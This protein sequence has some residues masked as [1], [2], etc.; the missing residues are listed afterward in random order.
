MLHVTCHFWCDG[1]PQ[2][3]YYWDAYKEYDK[4]I[5]HISKMQQ[6]SWHETSPNQN[7]GHNNI[8]EVNR[9]A[10]VKI[11]PLLDTKKCNNQY[12]WCFHSSD[13]VVQN[14]QNL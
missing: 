9:E 12:W 6:N 5:S 14:T 11:L 2:M 10:K 8:S 1:N 7:K 4:M 13:L 3:I